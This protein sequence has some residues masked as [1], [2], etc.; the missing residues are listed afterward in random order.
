MSEDDLGEMND[1][2][3][4]NHF[5]D[6]SDSA[7]FEAIDCD[8]NMA[9]EEVDG[10]EVM[11]YALDFA[12]DLLIIEDFVRDA[13]FTTDAAFAIDEHRSRR[14]ATIN[15]WFDRYHRSL[16]ALSSI[17]RPQY[18]YSPRVE[19]VFSLARE[20]DFLN[21]L[22]RN[23]NALVG[24][25]EEI[26]NGSRTIVAD[27]YNDLIER[28]RGEY[29]KRKIGRKISKRIENA[30][31]NYVDACH[32][33]DWIMA[34]F[35]R[36]AVVR[37]DVGYRKEDT[38]E[39]TLECAMNDYRKL[40]QKRRGKQSVF[41]EMVGYVAKLEYSSVKGYHFHFMLFFNGA[42]KRNHSYLAEQIGTYWRDEVT[43]G[44]GTYYNCNRSMNKYKRCGIGL[45]DH[46]DAAKRSN[47]LFA[48]SYLTKSEQYV[49]VKTKSGQRTFFK[50]H[51]RKHSQKGGR[52]RRK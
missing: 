25:A 48:L 7:L 18:Q 21:D 41:G 8:M 37:L 4:V 5:D 40:I 3:D 34:R 36:I 24:C 29:K 1:E 20:F 12:N 16:T 26:L 17:C 52:P 42:K 13:V 35:A 30:K 44:A 15:K 9:S 50:G 33:V 51:K 6:F 14:V 46:W 2:F 27:C 23:P 32:Y 43:L 22:S 38:V 47:L 19:L 28:L 39:T 11:I 31:N 49:L 10:K 45:V